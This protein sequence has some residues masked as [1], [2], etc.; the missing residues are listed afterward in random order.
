M[1]MGALTPASGPSLAPGSNT[2]CPFQYLDVYLTPGS[3]TCPLELDSVLLYLL[4]KQF[5]WASQQRDR[6]RS[7]LSAWGPGLAEL[8]RATSPDDALRIA[9]GL[10]P[11]ERSLGLEAYALARGGPVSLAEV[12]AAVYAT[13]SAE[14]VRDVLLAGCAMLSWTFGCCQKC[15]DCVSIW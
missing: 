1:G 10:T 8:G 7:Y 6:F 11:A 9:T 4:T 5:S 2:S 13:C 14:Q 12:T 3:F 15:G